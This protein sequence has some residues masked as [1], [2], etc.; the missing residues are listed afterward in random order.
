MTLLA[1]DEVEL[2]PSDAS[3]AAEQFLRDALEGPVSPSRS[4]PTPRPTA[5]P[6]RTLW[7]AKADL[8]VIADR[9]QGDTK[10]PWYWLFPPEESEQ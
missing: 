5:S 1:G 7:R 2:E 9:V 8:G 3:G 4:W 6:R 10:A